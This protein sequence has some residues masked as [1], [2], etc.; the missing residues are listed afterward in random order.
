MEKCPGQAQGSGNG[1]RRADFQ[2]LGPDMKLL[3]EKRNLVK[4]LAHL[5][6]L[7]GERLPWIMKESRFQE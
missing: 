2:G 5:L 4:S 6:Y 1:E 7:E 3:M